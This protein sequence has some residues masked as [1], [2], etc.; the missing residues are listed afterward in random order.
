MFR[1]EA[2]FVWA[3]ILTF[4]ACQGEPNTLPTQNVTSGDE[5]LADGGIEDFA[6]YPDI[7]E[8]ESQ[9][10]DRSFENA[11]PLIPHTVKGMM[12]ITIEHNECLLCHSPEKAKEKEAT[13]ISKTH[14]INY[15][16]EILEKEGKYELYP[17]GNEVVQQQLG[18]MDHSMYN[19][20]QCHVPQADITVQIE[21]LFTPEFRASSSRSQS[22]LSE[23]MAEGVK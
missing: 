2:I 11:P 19:C 13:P 6:T 9:S 21:N 12:V 14:F 7:A 22:N 3:I 18:K 15:R 8:I 23:N 10:M 4:L 20:N 16:P 17:E 5:L 1:L